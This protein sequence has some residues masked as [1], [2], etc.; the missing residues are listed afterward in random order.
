MTNDNSTFLIRCDEF[1]LVWG[2]LFILR[3]KELKKSFDDYCIK[4][5]LMTHICFFFSLIQSV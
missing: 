4:G 1:V 5:I 2:L 3:Q